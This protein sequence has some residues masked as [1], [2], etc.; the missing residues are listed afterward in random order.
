LGLPS[1]GRWGD[2]GYVIFRVTPSG[3]VAKLVMQDFYFRAPLPVDK[4]PA[5][6]DARIDDLKDAKVNFPFARQ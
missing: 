2:V 3:A 1:T 6:W 4:R 5:F